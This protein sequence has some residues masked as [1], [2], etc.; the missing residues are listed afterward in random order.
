MKKELENSLFLSNHISKYPL[1]CTALVC[2]FCACFSQRH[3]ISLYTSEGV[4]GE[5]ALL[6]LVPAFALALIGLA[7]Y[8]GA[9]KSAEQSVP[10]RTL[11]ISAGVGVTFLC[12]RGLLLASGTVF[13]LLIML[14]CVAAFIT[15]FYLFVNYKKVSSALCVTALLS[16]GFYIGFGAWFYILGVSLFFLYILFCDETLLPKRIASAVVLALTAVLV[17]VLYS[18]AD[19]K[20]SGIFTAGVILCIGGFLVAELRGKSKIPPAI[21][22]MFGV[23]LL[24][25]LGYVLDIELPYNQHDVFSLFQEKYPRHNSYIMYIYENWS[26]PT[27]SVY[28]AGLSQYYHPPLYH[29]LAALWMKLQTLFGVDLYAAYENVQYFTMFCSAAMMTAA[30][31]LFCEFKLKGIALYT[32]FALIAFHPTFFIF[33]GSVNNDPL[34]TLFLFLAVLYTVRW[35]KEQSIKNSLLLAICIGG[36]MMSKLS[37]A[38]VAVGT[39]YVMLVRLFDKSTGGF[40]C[41]FKRLWS[42]FVAFGAV[43]FPMGLWWPIRCAV[44]YGMPLGYVPA[45]SNS[46]VL[47]VGDYS[48]IQRLTGI[49][50]WSLS[51]VY[52]NVGN[53]TVDG[54]V[55][56]EGAKR[57]Y[58]Y[59]IAPYIVKS[60]LFGEYFWKNGVSGVQNILA[61]VMTFSAIAL[62]CVSLYAMIKLIIKTKGEYAVSLRFLGVYFVALVGSYVMFCFTYP[63]TCTMDFRYIVPTLLIAAVFS[64]LL[65]NN[66]EKRKRPIKYTLFAITM[67]FCVASVGFYAL[68]Y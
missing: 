30:Y 62:I 39:A 35:Y 57:F 42:R 25:R 26:L 41:N 49:G 36:A 56:T 16:L 45:L 22:F 8:V 38:M 61:Y 34:T 17:P 9:V 3:Q 65:I 66:D 27:E 60:S 21:M 6:S 18:S 2:L 47:Y 51:N 53:T 28:N 37:G 20:T 7:L 24:M 5:F 50:S 40:V 15:A 19:V 55:V 54:S 63:H 44:K 48:F 67:V 14:I 46:S 52:P 32:A 58:D 68:S 11:Y 64:G 13:K 23:G 33:S 59:G 29:F 1:A 31:K 10:K 12:C 4:N 43:C